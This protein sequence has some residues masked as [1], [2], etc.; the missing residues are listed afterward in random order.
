MPFFRVGGAGTHFP[1]RDD[2][3]KPI[4][5]PNMHSPASVFRPLRWLEPETP[6]AEDTTDK[7]LE[8]IGYGGEWFDAH[9][10]E[11]YLKTKGVFLDGTSSFIEIDPSTISLPALTTTASTPKLDQTG[12]PIRT[13]S[14]VVAPHLEGYLDQDVQNAFATN[15]IFDFMASAGKPEDPQWPNTFDF[16]FAQHSPDYTPTLQDV[17]GN[18]QTPVTIDV[19]KFLERMVDGSA[20]LGRAPGF[21][22]SHIDNCLA[23]SLQ[24]AF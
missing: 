18:R 21:R 13:P 14:P 23:L 6:R 22:K 19:S 4:Y 2:N 9:D 10:V 11:E 17:L 16:G 15:P 20:C 5:P 7:M 1:R 3:G 8:A 24:E 12:S